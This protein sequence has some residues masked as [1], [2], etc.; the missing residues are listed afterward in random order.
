MYTERKLSERQILLNFLYSDSTSN[1]DKAHII[2]TFPNYMPY[3]GNGFIAVDNVELAENLLKDYISECNY[4][5]NYLNCPSGK[6]I[7]HLSGND[8]SY[9][10]LMIPNVEIFFKLLYDSG[11]RIFNY[12]LTEYED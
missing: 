6:F 4:E 2:A 9:G 5:E 8:L 10:R 1:E 12:S 7:K 3:K 11:V